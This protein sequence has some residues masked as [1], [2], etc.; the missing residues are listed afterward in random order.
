MGSENEACLGGKG[1]EQK[2]SDSGTARSPRSALRPWFAHGDPLD[3]ETPVV[4]TQRPVRWREQPSVSW[5]E[6]LCYREQK[7]SV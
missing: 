5:L 6:F 4:C 7:T 3:G 2:L 1:R